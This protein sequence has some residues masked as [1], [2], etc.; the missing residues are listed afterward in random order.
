[1]S[2]N[3]AERFQS[4][5]L[6]E[7]I[8]LIAAPLL[9]INSFLPWYDVELC[10][11]DICAS[12]TRSGWESPGAIWSILATLIAIIM[13]GVIVLTRFTNVEVPRDFGNNIT[14]PKIMLGLGVAAALFV[15]LKLLNESSYLGFGF[16]LGILLVAALVVGGFLMF[17][18]EQKGGNSAAM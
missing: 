6:G 3:F 12:E 9:L 13:G 4:M 2:I 16:Y 10:F 17:Q 18:E 7:K 11:G 8:I 14:W 5:S 15:L 1:M